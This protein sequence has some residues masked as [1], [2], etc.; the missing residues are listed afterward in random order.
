MEKKDSAEITTITSED[1]G[2]EFGSLLKAK[3]R[4]VKRCVVGKGLEVVVN[5]Q[6]DFIK[7]G[8]GS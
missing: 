6:I 4:S 1:I 5:K 2:C 7:P 8:L 3:I